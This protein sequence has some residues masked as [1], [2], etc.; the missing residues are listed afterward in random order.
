MIAGRGVAHSERTPP[1]VRARGSRT[2]G[3]QTWVALPREH[4]AMAPAFEHHPQHTLPRIEQPGATLRVIASTAYGRT[5]PTSVLV[6][7]LYV[8][9]QLS[10]GATLAIDAEHAERAAYVIDGE[11]ACDGRTF[12]AATLIVL[13]PHLHATVCARTPANIMLVGGAPLD[14]PRHLWW[15][16]VASDRARIEQAKAD[17]SDGRF[18]KVFGDEHEFVPLPER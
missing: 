4:E 17:W 10:A 8:H 6:P 11:I 12:G 5:A 2:L 3:L 1:E 18:A 15:N 13:R 7:T 14:G 9:A 16:F